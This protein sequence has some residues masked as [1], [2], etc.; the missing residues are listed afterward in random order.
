M[1]RFSR[2]LLILSL[3]LVSS[4]NSA[5]ARQVLDCPMRDAPFSLQSPFI[6]VLLNPHARQ[7]AQEET[8]LDFS[9]LRPLSVSTTPPSFAAILTTERALSI[10]GAAPTSLASLD[11][12]LRKLPV[13]GSD[14]LARCDRYD[15]VVPAFT[16]KRGQGPRLLI[17][18]KINGFRDEPSVV[19]A[20]E[21]LTAMAQTNGWR[22]LVTD[23]G[24]VFNSRSLSQFDL[25]IWNN[26]SGDVLT[27][28]QRRAFKTYLERGGGFIGLHGS[29]GDPVYFWDWYADKLIGARFSGHPMAPQFQEARIQVDQ[30]HPLSK[31]LPAEW[32]MTDEWYSF[33]TNPRASGAK[34]V[35]MLDESTY[36]RTG[37]YGES[38]DMGDHPLAWTRCTGRGRAFYSAIGHLP[39]TY[40]EP[41]HVKL[42]KNAVI[43]AADRTSAC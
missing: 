36:S 17:F 26:I 4:A 16:F 25:V 6:D 2:W 29:A 30:S 5:N 12:K 15:K 11:L 23:K 40:H 34:I 43:W 14:R 19:A 31:D 1:V 10:A 35:L 37:L 41:N 13:R 32:R 24:G 18:E 21:A 27:L 8:K 38:L 7:L 9:K 33:R 42:L 22:Y 39:E 20:R 3:A 28:S